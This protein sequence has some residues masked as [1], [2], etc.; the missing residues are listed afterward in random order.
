MFRLI[1]IYCDTYCLGMNSSDA[2]D[3]LNYI[4]CIISK[5]PIFEL[6]II[7]LKLKSRS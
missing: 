4:K 6:N 7:H 3:L 2:K 1:K 5:K